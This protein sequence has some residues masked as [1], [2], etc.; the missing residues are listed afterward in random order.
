MG[1]VLHTGWPQAPALSEQ[2]RL[3]QNVRTSTMHWKSQP[4]L[5]QYGSL[6]QIASVH[7]SQ[8]AS[9]GDPDVHLPRAHTVEQVM[10]AASTSASRE[11]IWRGLDVSYVPD[12]LQLVPRTR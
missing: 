5:Q 9:I 3:P 6:R 12:P 1:P 11:P 10:G 4:V 7:E 8:P 2:V